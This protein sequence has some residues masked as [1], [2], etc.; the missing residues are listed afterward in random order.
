[1]R[2]SPNTKRC[3]PNRCTS[4]PS[5]RIWRPPTRF[6]RT[7][8]R[9]NKY[10]TVAQSGTGGNPKLGKFR[11]GYTRKSLPGQSVFRH[12]PCGNRGQQI[13]GIKSAEC[14]AKRKAQQKL[15]W[16][17][18]ASALTFWL[19]LA[20]IAQLVEQLICNSKRAFCAVFQGIAQRVFQS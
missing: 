6:P 19:F 18:A 3:I 17:S 11:N 9:A 10:P 16:L 5:S 7:L 4:A 14:W 13:R 8:A 1:G 15:W 2:R 12:R 20:G